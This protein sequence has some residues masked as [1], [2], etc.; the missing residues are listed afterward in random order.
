MGPARLAAA[1]TAEI[2]FP[3]GSQ[4]GRIGGMEQMIQVAGG[5]VWADTPVVPEPR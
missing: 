1:W 5:T 3:P 2:H 4:R